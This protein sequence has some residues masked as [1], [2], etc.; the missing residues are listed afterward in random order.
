VA[1][2][3]CSPLALLVALYPDRA[4]RSLDSVRD[5]PWCWRRRSAPRPSLTKRD[6]R[7]GLSISIA[8][9][10]TG[11]LAALALALTFALERDGSPSRWR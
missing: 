7:P 3:S 5:W 10:A 8:L 6:S 11:S 1:A 4:S 2:A 9:F